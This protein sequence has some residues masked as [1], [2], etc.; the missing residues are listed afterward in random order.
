MTTPEAPVSKTETLRQVMDRVNEAERELHAAIG[1]RLTPGTWVWVS[2][3]ANAVP[4]EVLWTNWRRI[5][6]R[7]H[8]GR[9]YGVDISRLLYLEDL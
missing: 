6:V 5:G 7:S 8:T 3:G 9:E 1:A 4:A 2:W